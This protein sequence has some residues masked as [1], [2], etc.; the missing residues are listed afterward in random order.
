MRSN[1]PTFLPHLLLIILLSG[2]LLSSCSPT[3]H[4]PDG[5]YLLDKVEIRSDAKEIN[6]NDLPD[7]IRQMPNSHILGIFR[8]QL[9]IYNLAGKDTTK[10]VST[11]LRRIGQQPVLLDTMLMDISAQQLHRF[12]VNKGYYDASV[13]TIVNKRNKRARV[14]Y[15]VQ[16]N[17]PYRIRNYEVDIPFKE[18]E[19]MA[20]DSI[21]SLIQPHML[22]DVYELDR[23]RERLTTR[24]RR[25]GY[26]N[27]MKDYL[28]YTADTTGYVVDVTLHLRDYLMDNIDTLRHAVF[29]QYNISKVIYNLNPSVSTIA[30]ADTP[31]ETDTTY[32][33]KYVVISPEKKFLNFNALTASTFIKPGAL[34]SDADVER[35]YAALNTLP[36]VKYTH[37]SFD[38]TAP[39]SLQ[40]LITIAE[41]KS[42]TFTSQAEITFTEGYW[43]T[44]GNMGVV[45][46]NLFKGAESLS[47]QGRLALERQGDV[48]AQ[49]WG[50]QVGIRVPRTILPF[51]SDSYSRTL[52]GSTEFR[53][54]F[55]YQFRPGE[56]SSTNVGGGVK[57]NWFKGRQNYNLDL[58]D[59]SYVYFPWI[60]EQFR[61]SFLVT[62]KYNRYNYDDYLIMRVG[63]NTAASGYNP[64][65]P[66]RNYLTYRYGVECAG[67]ALYG[68]YKLLNIPADAEGFYR[69]FNIRYSQYV[70]GEFNASYHQILD[71]NN[72]FVYRAGMGAGIPYGNSE[73]IP[74]E[75]RFYS[76][77]ANSV[78]GWGESMLGPGTYERFS[79]LRRRDYNQVGDIKLD[80]NVEYRTKMFWVL[81]GAL[82][83]DAGNIWTIR[84]YDNQ[85][86]GVF[87]LDSFWKE[88]ALA[89]GMGIRMDFNFFLFRIDMGVKLYDPA[90]VSTP[91][92][93]L[94]SFKD[95][96]LHIAIGY[97]F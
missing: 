86:G 35:T 10:W 9:G 36:P 89:Y 45:H 19:L 58:L 46:R 56:F 11:T 81:E 70:K 69:A 66:L 68:I 62:G 2:G 76:G 6:K 17:R 38:E 3:R 55:N 47:V 23:E 82:F 41:A 96:A 4:V 77:G 39:D 50:G 27:F 13:N 25:Q 26:Y 53:T 1:H 40:C 83:A 34:Y 7:Y 73:I 37:I 5:A 88:I 63:Y 90:A 12:H 16:S 92:W 71:K 31:S 20:K 78:R 15:Q 28:A 75:R 79:T 57:Y 48:I 87:R 52:Q 44:A 60:S 14:S 65:R 95:V 42:F 84:E 43:G 51:I 22:F 54:T 61:D 91:K 74:F 24:M 64:A 85:P 72:K 94:P 8:L 49:E 29:K 67:N 18:L 30:R 21:R 33:D 93:I 97:P 59:I 80:L 32:I